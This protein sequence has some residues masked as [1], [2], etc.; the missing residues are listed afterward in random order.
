MGVK[1]YDNTTPYQ[2][3]KI[4]S[5]ETRDP[6]SVEVQISEIELPGILLEAKEA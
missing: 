4:L 3:Y 6:N 5:P 1:F 2:D